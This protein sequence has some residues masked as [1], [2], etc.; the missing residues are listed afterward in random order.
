MVTLN[1]M[2][3]WLTKRVIDEALTLGQHHLLIPLSLAVVGVAALRGVAAFFQRYSMEYVAQHVVYDMRSDL[4][5]HLQ[6]LSFSYYDDMRTGQLMAR[7][8]G[9]VETL[10]RMIGFGIINLL[11]NI[12]TFGIVLFLLFSLHWRLALVSLLLMPF[13]VY[14]VAQFATKVRPAYRDIQAQLA[15]LTSTLQENVTGVRV[16][17]AFAQEESEREK[18]R[19][20]NEGYFQKE[21]RAV[22]M[23]AFY[24]PLMN[25]LSQLGTVFV[26]WYGGMEVMQGRLTLGELVAFNAYLLMLIM[27]L[28][29]VGWIVNLYQRGIASGERVF[30]VLDEPILIEEKPGARKLGEIEGHVRLDD[31]FFVYPGASEPVLSHINI[32]AKPGQIIALLGGTGSG[33]STLVSLIPRFHDPS[34]GRVLIDGEDIRDVTLSSLRRQ[35]GVVMQDTFLF[36]ATILENISYGRP[37]ASQEEIEWAARSAR[38]HDFIMTLPKGYDTVVGERGVGLSGGQKQRVAIARTLLI[39]PGVL[40]LDDAT[41]SVDT[42]TE[43]L[44]QQALAVLMENRTTFV[45]S[46]RLSSI[47]DADEIIVLEDGRVVER[48]THEQLMKTGRRYQEIYQL[49]VE[50]GRER[51]DPEQGGGMA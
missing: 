31:V 10:R 23:W 17:R 44:I 39:N 25:F 45:I 12:F 34:H 33:K 3:P 11:S 5:R 21:L 9:D 16:V 20:V 14:T 8:T 40:I 15:T 29:M 38:I 2:I 47:K 46:Q 28:R 19:H 27:P 7:V 13:L 4:Y 22:K 36:S 49:Q 41:S 48:G 6:A 42:E 51:I 1:M 37:D 30:E 32:E 43:H 26:I 50:D 35:V 18:F 24:F